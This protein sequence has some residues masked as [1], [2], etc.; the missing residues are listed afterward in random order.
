MEQS[1]Q[2]WPYKDPVD[3]IVHKFRMGDV[4]D[5]DLYAAQPL[6]DWEHSEIGQWVMQHSISTPTWYRVADHYN[7]GHVYIVKATFDSKSHL[8]WKLKYAHW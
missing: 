2:Q 4:D 6:Y 1:E 3:V 8:I 7:F 5:P